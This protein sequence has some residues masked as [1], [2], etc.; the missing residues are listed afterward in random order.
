MYLCRLLRLD[1]LIHRVSPCTSPKRI[2]DSYSLRVIP[3]VCLH[4]TMYSE[5]EKTLI[6]RY[7]ICIFH[8]RV[9]V[10]ASS[11]IAYTLTPSSH[12]LRQLSSSLTLL[13]I[14]VP[15]FMSNPPICAHIYVQS[16]IW[17]L[18]SNPTFGPSFM[19]NPTFGPTTLRVPHL[20]ARCFSVSVL[21]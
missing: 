13:P 16:H 8:L 12:I 15:S 5:N 17:A 7:T 6:P 14:F 3:R 20:C 10:R 4:T 9:C 21:L 18:I 2:Q 11:L 1:I 19:S